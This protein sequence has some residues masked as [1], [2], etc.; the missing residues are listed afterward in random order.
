LY[1]KFSLQLGELRIVLSLKEPDF[2]MTDQQFLLNATNE[3]TTLGNRLSL[4]M[5][6]FLNE[7]KDQPSGFRNLGLDFLSLCQILNTLEGQLKE[8]FR[9]QQPFPQAAVP[10]LRQLLTKTTDDFRKLQNLLQK[11]MDYEKGGVVAK[12]Q[13]TWRQLFADKDIATVRASLQAH[14]G[15]LTM[16]MLL[17]NM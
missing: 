2:D 1:W 16:T 14:K 9:I 8:H 11:F 7:V 5:V 3:S 15:A 12:V 17:I 10:E 6:D 4:K 13:K